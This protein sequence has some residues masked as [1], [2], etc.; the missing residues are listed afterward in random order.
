MS[1]T[2]VNV[3]GKLF[4]TTKDTLSKCEYFAGLLAIEAKEEVPFVD[5]PGTG[6]KHILYYLQDDRYPFP[7]Q[8]SLE[9]DFYGVAYPKYSQMR[10]KDKV[11]I[12]ASGEKFTVHAGRLMKG[13][14]YFEKKLSQLY[15]GA[16]FHIRGSAKG[17]SHLMRRIHD[18]NHYIPYKYKE[19]FEK[20]QGPSIVWTPDT[21][22]SH[23]VDGTK[24][25][26]V[27]SVLAK[28]PYLTDWL[29]LG[30]VTNLKVQIKAWTN[31]VNHLRDNSPALLR[32]QRWYESLQV[33]PVEWYRITYQ[34]C[35]GMD[36]IINAKRI[37]CNNIISYECSPQY[38][39][40]HGCRKCPLKAFQNG[41]CKNH[42]Q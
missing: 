42:Q 1:V 17:F 21:L 6:F 35:P 7:M 22:V 20:Y 41:L 36:C 29:T 11:N 2:Q 4:T 18:R 30:F 28:I 33:V 16:D 5:R 15:V 3:G 38:C 25:Y 39:Y 24:V 37:V 13:S 8:F 9:L 10:T 32:Y 14:P 27:Y 26:T 19:E 40:N 31:I 12:F 23:L 34:R